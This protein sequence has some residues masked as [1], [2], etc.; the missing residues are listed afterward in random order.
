MYLLAN[1]TN[2]KRKYTFEKLKVLQFQI[3]VHE[4]TQIKIPCRE[5]VK[6]T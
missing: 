3:W 1:N 2:D 4:T 5:D 6:S